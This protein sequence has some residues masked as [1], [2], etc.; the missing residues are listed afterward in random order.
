MLK[1]EIGGRR[2]ERSEIRRLAAFLQKRRKLLQ[3]GRKLQVT[4]SVHLYR[5]K[6][7]VTG[8]R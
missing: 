5:G 8:G 1:A 6:G 2:S 3:T 7:A 4:D